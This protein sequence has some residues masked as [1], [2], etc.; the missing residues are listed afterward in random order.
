[1]ISFCDS[2]FI[3]PSPMVSKA[4]FAVISLF[5]WST[6]F[7][8]S[9]QPLLVCINPVLN[10]N[11][12]PVGNNASPVVYPMVAPYSDDHL[13]A[14]MTIFLLRR[15]VFQ[16]SSL[17]VVFWKS[18]SLSVICHPWP[19]V[20]SHSSMAI[21]PSPPLNSRLRRSPY[22]RLH[23]SKRVCLGIRLR[24]LCPCSVTTSCFGGQLPFLVGASLPR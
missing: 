10:N 23:A 12:S 16:Y 5:R 24:R 13:H 9:Q 14:P 21:N 6:P 17:S 1:M 20:D 18:T 22:S 2:V 4:S 3:Y 19:T 15:S 11:P 7:F 8:G